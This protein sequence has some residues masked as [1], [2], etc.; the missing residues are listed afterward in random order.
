MTLCIVGSLKL[1][2]WMVLVCLVLLIMT[3]NRQAWPTCICTAKGVPVVSAFL[4]GHA[5]PV[6]QCWVY[7]CI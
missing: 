6:V 2:W 5:L 4:P 3:F 1:V 7:L